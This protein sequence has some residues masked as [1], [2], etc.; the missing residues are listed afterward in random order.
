MTRLH[1]DDRQRAM[2]AEMGIQVWL[3]KAPVSPSEQGEVSTAIAPETVA[4]R[5]QAATKNIALE[6][7]EHAPGAVVAPRATPLPP[8]Q[9][10]ATAARQPHAA[11]Q[12]LPEH[13]D[14]AELQDAVSQ[15][16]ACG[17][18]EGRTNTVFGVGPPV[19]EGSKTPVVDWLV[20]G[21]APG[22][23]ED[24]SGEP[25]VGQAGQLLDNMLKSIGLDRQR[26]VY[27]ANVIKCRPPHNRNPEA[28]EIAQCAPYLHRQIALLQPKIILALGRFAVNTLLAQTQPDV[29]KQPLGRLRGQVHHY[30]PGPDAALRVPVVASYHP[31]YLLRNLPEKAKSWADLVLALEAL[32]KPL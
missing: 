7:I 29:D 6:T 25:F 3:P 14:W 26:N 18:C 22:E 27:I 32:R 11:E 16:R 9:T 4:S 15:C 13:M 28:A 12:A 23:Q 31:A 20:V 19:G 5:P 8:A 2:L 17:L 10:L 1:L 21:E 24:K 30:Q